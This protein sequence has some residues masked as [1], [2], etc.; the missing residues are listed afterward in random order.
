MSCPMATNPGNDWSVNVPL[1]A[2]VALQELPERMQKLEA[3]NKQ[4]RREL[5]ALR[6]IQSQTLQL[7]A[8]FKRER[9]S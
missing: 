3:E 2:L 5:E 8:D 9:K 7:F 1:S 6:A 4:L